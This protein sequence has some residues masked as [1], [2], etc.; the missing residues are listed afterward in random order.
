MVRDAKKR[1]KEEKR[2]GKKKDL[3][4]KREKN[5]DQEKRSTLRIL[6]SIPDKPLFREFFLLRRVSEYH[7][8]S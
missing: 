1:R 5:N 7:R 8:D 6:D 4:N 2:K 3:E